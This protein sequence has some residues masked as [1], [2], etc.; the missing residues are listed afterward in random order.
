MR[1][2]EYLVFWNP[3]IYMINNKNTEEQLLEN[4]LSHKHPARPEMKK[5]LS[6]QQN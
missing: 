3:F 6:E 2:I 1:T 5:I 4:I